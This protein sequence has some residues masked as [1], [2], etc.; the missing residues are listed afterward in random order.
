MLPVRRERRTD[1][2]HQLLDK[3]YF[4]P[5]TAS[6]GRDQ[7][8]TGRANIIY[9]SDSCIAASLIRKKI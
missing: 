7:G 6:S 5:S 3:Y 8:T 9:F 4:M 2:I 1:E